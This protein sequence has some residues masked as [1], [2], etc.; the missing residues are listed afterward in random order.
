M[1]NLVIPAEA[2][3]ASNNQGSRKGELSNKTPNFDY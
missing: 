3:E 1:S 2:A